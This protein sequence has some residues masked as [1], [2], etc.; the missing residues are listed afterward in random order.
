VVNRYLRPY[1]RGQLLFLGFWLSVAGVLAGA[2]NYAFQ[3]L[4]GRMLNT[5]DYGTFGAMMALFSLLAVPLNTLMMIVSRKVSEYRAANDHQNI[6][7]FY[8]SVSLHVALFGIGLLCCAGIWVPE[9]RTYLKTGDT[10]AFLLG[11]LLAITSLTVLNNGFLQGQQKFRGLAL[12]NLS[13]LLLRLVVAATLAWSGNGLSGVLWGMVL[14]S[15]LNWMMSRYV[16]SPSTRGSILETLKA[17]HLTGEPFFKF[18]LSNLA[19]AALINVDVL[20]VMYYFPQHEV[21]LYTAASVLGKAAMYLPAGIS[22][23]LFPITAERHVRSER[24]ALLLVQALVSTVIISFMIASIYYFFAQDIILV[25]YGENY[26]SASDLLK[27]YGYVIIPLSLILLVESYVNAKGN[28]LFGY[29]FIAFAPLQLL[30]FVLCRDSL[31]SLISALGVGSLILL[32]VGLFLLK[33][34][35]VRN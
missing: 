4:V 10:E 35:N 8:H 29:L 23:A 25:V 16:I 27:Y 31:V 1:L 28:V 2:L 11:L 5:T 9:L 3:I 15:V 14:G 6:S 21:G 13:G 33:T 32:L 22:T 30:A 18:F 12:T 17:G 19:L 7:M 26:E 24:S 20:V 34:G